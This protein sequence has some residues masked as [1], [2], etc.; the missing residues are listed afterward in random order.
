MSIAWD[1]AYE[2][3]TR[4]V[5]PLFLAMMQ[6]GGGQYNCI[7]ILK[8]KYGNGDK[9]L[10]NLH[11]E[12]ILVGDILLKPY[13][14]LYEDDRFQLINDISRLSQYDLDQQA[15]RKLPAMSFIKNLIDDIFD[16]SKLY[17]NCAWYDGPY[18]SGLNS[19]AKNFPY[20]E[21]RDEECRLP[22][23]P[24]WTILYA[25]KTLAMCN[26]ETNELITHHGN[27]FDLQ[28]DNERG[29]ALLELGK[30]LKISEVE[31]T[32]QEAVSLIRSNPKSVGRPNKEYAEVLATESG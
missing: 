18:S 22:H 25:N 4:S 9:T 24:W 19:S 26:L 12:S 31:G 14:K 15:V 10:I 11:G 30:D 8:D 2:I 20:Y 32:A 23:F 3:M 17:I 5:T 13:Q 21:L 1:I 27:H 6:T 16:N 7:T 28:D 29:M